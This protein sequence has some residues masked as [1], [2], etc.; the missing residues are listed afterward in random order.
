MPMHNSQEVDRACATALISIEYAVHTLVDYARTVYEQSA[1][2]RRPSVTSENS[3]YIHRR[4]PSDRDSDDVRNDRAR[5]RY[6]DTCQDD[7]MSTSYTMS[8]KVYVYPYIGYMSTVYR[9]IYVRQAHMM[10]SACVK[11]APPPHPNGAML[12][13]TSPRDIVC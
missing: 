2:D 7:Y 4:A 13:P 1:C 6:N 3:A 9:Q 10:A 8:M 11:S 5:T 12:V